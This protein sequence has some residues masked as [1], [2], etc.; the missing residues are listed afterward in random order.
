[1]RRSAE[2]ANPTRHSWVCPRPGRS[3]RRQWARRPPEFASSSASGGSTIGGGLDA[4]AFGQWL[5]SLR[6]AFRTD[7]SNLETASTLTAMVP[8][9]GE[10]MGLAVAVQQ[11][12]KSAIAAGAVSLLGSVM[13]LLVS[14][15]AVGVAIGMI[16]MLIVSFIHAA[17]MPDPNPVAMEHLKNHRDKAFADMIPELARDFTLAM[18]EGFA[19][20]Q[21]QQIVALGLSTAA[22]ER[23]RDAALS[24]DPAHAATITEQAATATAALRT[25]LQDSLTSQHDKLISSLKTAFRDLVKS[26][27][28]KPEVE[29]IVTDTVFPLPELPGRY[30]WDDGVGGVNAGWVYLAA[31]AAS[32]KEFYCLYGR[33]QWATP[34][35]PEEF[36]NGASLQDCTNV[37]YVMN[38]MYVPN[39]KK[40]RTMSIMAPSDTVLDQAVDAALASPETAKYLT[41][42]TLP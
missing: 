3:S 35:T 11:G 6:D 23:T 34:R 13:S 22:I 8:L 38:N 21:G 30:S 14:N 20:S 17:S 7:T 37:L 10:S 9:L 31:V 27:V 24:A 4:L 42:A 5:T 36:A 41:V 15:P 32:E 19:T 16:G 26:E 40:L 28:S 1:M 29:R 12:D 33:D 25:Q 39:V 18:S 2:S